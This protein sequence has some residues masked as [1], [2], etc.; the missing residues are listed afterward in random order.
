MQFIS[1]QCIIEA[2]LTC[3]NKKSN[4]LSFCFLVSHTIIFLSS[5]FSSPVPCLTLHS[6]VF[7]FYFVFNRE[8]NSLEYF[9][10]NTGTQVGLVLN[11][12]FALEMTLILGFQVIISFTVINIIQSRYFKI[13]EKI[14]V[15]KRA[16]PNHLLPLRGL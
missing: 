15:R 12:F 11:T 6:C 7:C 13:M 10:G 3:R 5:H 2:K 16:W 4:A 8:R 1:G 9:R 14:L